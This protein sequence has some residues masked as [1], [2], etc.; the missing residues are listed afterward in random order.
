MSTHEIKKSEEIT[1]AYNQKNTTKRV[2]MGKNKTRRKEV[3][4]E[5]KKSKIT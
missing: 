4:K 3:E 5:I 1:F 2:K